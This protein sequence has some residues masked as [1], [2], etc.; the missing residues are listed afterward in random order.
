MLVIIGAVAFMIGF[1]LVPSVYRVSLL[2][3][4]AFLVA[5]GQGLC[6]PSLTSMISKV[7]PESER[8]SV[9]G[10]ATA[11]G[12]LARFL[13]PI[14]SGFLYDLGGPAGAFYGGALLM[15]CALTIAI[16]MRKLPV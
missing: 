8:G 6:Y 2:Y 12:S 7:A 11:V 5:I 15:L 10:L 4:V 9:L 1:A 16:S 14:V 3:V 13:G